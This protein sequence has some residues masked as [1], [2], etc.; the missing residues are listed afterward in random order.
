MRCFLL[1]LAALLPAAFGR[2]CRA[3]EQVAIRL[4]RCDDRFLQEAGIAA[5][6][7]DLKAA[8]KF[9][10]I[11][12]FNHP[13]FS[14]AS[15]DQVTVAA[16]G[17]APFPLTVEGTSLV[18]EFGKIVSAKLAFDIDK[19]TLAATGGELLILWG[20]GVTGSITLVDRIAPAADGA[21]AYLTFNWERGRGRAGGAGGGEDSTSNIEIIADSS[22]DLYFLWYL[23][24]MGLILAL[25]AIR[26]AA[27]AS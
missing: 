13:G 11:G 1:C 14:V 6:P 27:A 15:I 18:E 20:P 24:P 16:A 10:V 2:E 3:A 22:A 12:R 9:R 4:T 7:G 5:Q 25:L 26:K 23:L 21:A 17:G 8:N 19:E